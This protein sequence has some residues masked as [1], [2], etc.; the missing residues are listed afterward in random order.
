MNG[1]REDKFAAPANCIIHKDWWREILFDEVEENENQLSLA[2]FSYS[3]FN[4]FLFFFVLLNLQNEKKKIINFPHLRLLINFTP[5]PIHIIKDSMAFFHHYYYHHQHQ[6]R[7][8]FSSR[9]LRLY[10][11]VSL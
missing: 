5:L 7:N 8:F 1:Q 9:L 3:F 2:F 10:M 6:R 4:Q 11:C